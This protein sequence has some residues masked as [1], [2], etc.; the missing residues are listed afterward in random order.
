[1]EKVNENGRGWRWM[2]ENRVTDVQS[3]EKMRGTEAFFLA[4]LENG[5]A[6]RENVKVRS[7]TRVVGR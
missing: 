5:R 4:K 6:A 2:N 3:T 1:M 7:Q